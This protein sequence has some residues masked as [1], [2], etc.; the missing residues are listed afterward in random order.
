MST[1]ESKVG[2]LRNKEYRNAYVGEYL[3]T[4]IAYQVRA[5][6][7]QRNWDQQKL[8]ENAGMLQPRISA[9]ENPSNSKL[10][11]DTLLRLASAFDVALEV[12]FA[13]FSDLLRWGEGFSPDTFEVNSFDKD[14]Y[15]EHPINNI[16]Q[17]IMTTAV[18][19]WNQGMVAFIGTT[20]VTT[21]VEPVNL[22]TG[23]NAY[24]VI[25]TATENSY[26]RQKEKTQ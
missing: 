15:L 16:H 4:N 5:L 8:A 20:E 26:A 23:N 18:Q 24:M 19:A 1:R 25:P 6:R 7:K 17:A 14:C 9:I 2:K 10:N 11:L 12:R 21:I 22:P 13:A 3:H